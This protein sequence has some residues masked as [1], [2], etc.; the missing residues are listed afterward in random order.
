M[1]RSKA[2][3]PLAREHHSALVLARRLQQTG[4]EEAT[5]V[6]DLRAAWRELLV[7]HFDCE[8]RLLLPALRAAGEQTLVER[9]LAEHAQLR[10]LMVAIEAGDASAIARF[11]ALLSAHIRFEDRELFVRAEA[12]YAAAELMRLMAEP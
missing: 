11:G 9:T 1:K 10:A 5:L 2:L 6:A 3:A 4:Q 12:R 7:L 8:E